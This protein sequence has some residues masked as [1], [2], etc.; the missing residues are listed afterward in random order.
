[1]NRPELW[2]WLLIVAA[3]G[4]VSLQL[5][6]WRRGR[7]SAARALTGVLARTGFLLLGII[8]VT[9]LIVRY[10]RAPLYGLSVVG[11]GI[12]LHLLAG[13]V[14]RHRRATGAADAAEDQS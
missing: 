7:I 2:G 5:L 9:D 1:M 11:V 10:P 14:E 6:H 12:L 13:V 3:L 8:Y 4:A